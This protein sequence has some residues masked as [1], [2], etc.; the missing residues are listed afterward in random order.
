[1]EV[2]SVEVQRN[3]VTPAE[4]FAYVKKRCEK[5]GLNFEIDLDEFIK[6]NGESDRSY[7]VIVDEVTGKKEKMACFDGTKSVWDGEDAAAKAEICRTLPCDW[8]TYV[9]NWDGSCWNEICEFRFTD[10]RPYNL[11]GDTN[12]RGSGY[13]YQ[14]DRR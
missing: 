8:Q 2:T 3:N 5:K 7:R 9:L 14:M 10:C 6:P 12:K 1:M 13:Y 11:N 4:F